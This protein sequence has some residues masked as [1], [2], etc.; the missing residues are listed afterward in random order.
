MSVERV[1]MKKQILS[2]IALV[3]KGILVG[4][5]AIMPGIS[6]GSLLYAF[7]IYD[8][9]LEVLANPIKGIAKHWKM[10]CCVGLGGAIGFLGLASVV[11]ALLEW[12]ESVV[13]SV[14]VGLIIGTL[15]GLW[16]D[17]GKEGRGKGSLIS[18]VVSFVAITVL[19]F[20]FEHFW[21][22]SIP[23]N[24]FGWIICGLIWGLGFVVP[25]LASSNLLMFFGIY[26]VLL[27]NIKSFN[28]G[29]LIPF[30]LSVLVVFLLLSKVMKLVLDKYNSIVLH[31]ILGFVTAT[32]IMILPSFNTSIP[33]IIIYIACIAAGAVGSYFAMKLC[34]KL[35]AP[36]EEICEQSPDKRTKK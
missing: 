8:K 16:K 15:P 9:I 29:V 23:Q 19:F 4:F 1:T 33:N 28:L 10:L 35:E 14:F 21:H 18:L 13:I 12:N 20:M 27:A 2:Y 17:A 34:D 7:G 3:F 31:C 24:T 36:K 6:G 26:T 25:G 30:V 22:I 11:S 5:G 32:T